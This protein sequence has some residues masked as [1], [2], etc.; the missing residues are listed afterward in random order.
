MSNTHKSATRADE[1][2]DDLDFE[3]V[4]APPEK[5]MKGGRK[6]HQLSHQQ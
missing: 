2:S 5:K 3:V 1:M 4:L 6:E